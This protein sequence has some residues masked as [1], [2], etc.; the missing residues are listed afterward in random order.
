M[1]WSVTKQ[2][3]LF[4]NFP[5]PILGFKQMKLI[6]R[7]SRADKYKKYGPQSPDCY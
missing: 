6:L 5:K 2:P 4:E 7:N 3:Y 1:V